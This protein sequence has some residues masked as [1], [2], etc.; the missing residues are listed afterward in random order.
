VARPRAPSTLDFRS[1]TVTQPTDAMRHAMAMAQVGDDVYDEDPTVHKLQAKAAKLVGMEAALLVPTGTMGNQVAVWVHARSGAIVCE[2][3]CHLSLYEGGAAAL[4]SNVSLKTVAGPLGTFAPKDIERFFLPRDPHF[5]QVKAVAIENTHNYSGGRTWSAA[6]TKAIADTAHAKDAKLHIDGARIFNAAI[7][8]KTTAA[9]LCKP[10]DSVMFCL[11]KGLSAPIGSLVCGSQEFVDQAR[12]VRKTLGGG[13]R[14]AGHIA[15]AG[16]VAL[17]TCIDRLADDHRNAKLLAK[18]LA[19]LPGIK[20]DPASVE[21]NMVMADISATGLDAPKFIA[22]CK[23]QGI[24][25]GARSAEPVVRFVTHR[26]VSTA[27]CKEALERVATIAGPGAG[28]GTRRKV[29]FK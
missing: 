23:E 24:L 4:L 13:M 20:V 28:A 27:D 5:S 29:P 17:D 22:T 19:E 9:A 10:A 21:T 25:I 26:N 7:A 11:S 6:Q 2:E 15:A 3:N 1:D 14:Q 12:F 8:R 18:G 16:L